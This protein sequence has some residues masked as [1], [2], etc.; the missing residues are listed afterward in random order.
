MEQTNTHEK[1]N[2]AKGKGDV[3]TGKEKLLH[4]KKNRNDRET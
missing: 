2:K 1:K 4:R 3:T